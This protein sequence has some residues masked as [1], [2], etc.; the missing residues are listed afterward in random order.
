MQAISR[1]ARFWNRSAQKYA[2]SPIKDQAGYERTILHT[3]RLLRR[4]DVVV[5]LGC[6]TGTTALRLAPDVG[7][8][9]GTD[10]SMDMIEIARGKAAAQGCANAEFRVLSAEEP[11]VGEGSADA[12]LAF[13]L[14][15]LI[16]DRAT[17]Y[18][19]V[20]SLLKPG[21][22]FISKTP[23]LEEMSALLRV[24]VP[25][26]QLA[27][28]APSVSFFSGADLESEI[29][30]AGF[31]IIERARHG[32]GSKDPRLFLVARKPWAAGAR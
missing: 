28:M 3:T 2:R 14:L 5:E 32:S 15:H 8:I 23:C 21:G 6:G 13:N 19:Q 26:M 31:A 30:A 25:A 12:V 17:A 4:S 1:D 18:R 11:P 22:L 27:G 10:I 24:A 16:Y 9:V 7:S 20:L 29:E